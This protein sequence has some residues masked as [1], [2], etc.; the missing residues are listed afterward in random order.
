M[1]CLDSLRVR[2]DRIFLLH[3]DHLAVLLED[4]LETRDRRVVL[5]EPDAGREGD[6]DRDAEEQVALSAL[7]PCR[8]RAAK[9]HESARNDKE[10]RR[11]HQ[12]SMRKSCMIRS[13]RRAVRTAGT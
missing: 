12:L 3:A 5:D 1:K 2:D 8:Q 13:S 9:F 7:F 4:V 11:T 6:G 10:Q